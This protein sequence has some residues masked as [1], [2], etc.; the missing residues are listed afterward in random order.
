M[1]WVT[2]KLDFVDVYKIDVKSP[3]L[4]SSIN[5]STRIIGEPPFSTYSFVKSTLI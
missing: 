1:P 2:I 5:S 4:P 3:W